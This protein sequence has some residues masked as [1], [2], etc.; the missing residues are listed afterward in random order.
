MLHGLQGMFL[1]IT[2]VLSGLNNY[3]EKVRS[4]EI[5]CVGASSHI[6]HLMKEN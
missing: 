5:N 4:L 1:P 3:L 6:A 2:V